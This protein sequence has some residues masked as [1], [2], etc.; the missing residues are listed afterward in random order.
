M[1]VWTRD[2]GYGSRGSE[3]GNRRP[4]CTGSPV[5]R[6]VAGR[7]LVAQWRRGYE[8]LGAVQTPGLVAG[9][10][11]VSWL[12][13][14]CG[15]PPIGT[16]TPIPADVVRP[17]QPT[18][19][20]PENA[21][22]FTLATPSRTPIFVPTSTPLP[23][24]AQVA[25]VEA[26]PDLRGSLVLRQPPS[27]LGIASG[28]AAIYDAPGG[29][30]VGRVPVGGLL[31]VTGRSADGRWL[32][33]YNE[34]AVFGWTPAG[35]LRL[36]G[37]EDLVVVEEAVDPAP[38]ATLLARVMEPVAVIDDILAAREAAAT[39]TA[40]APPPG[41]PT[42]AAISGGTI[43]PP[44]A[45]APGPAAG[46]NSL[47][48]TVT[49]SADVAGAPI[50]ALQAT[51]SAEQR[52]NLRTRPTTTAAI[53]AK[54]APGAAVQVTGRTVA[55][56]WLRVEAALGNGWIAAELVQVAGDRARLPIVSAE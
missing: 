35:Q 36:F 54:L 1:E 10:V 52:V 21:R 3:V 8:R 24:A 41:T 20:Y 51:I 17:V 56:D 26:P 14:A 48:P 4:G 40:Q 50:G 47:L 28:G 5:R 25:Q 12:L 53:V 46:A 30:A 7:S 43:P 13:A 45:A 6:L 33:V 15:G 11:L 42:G 49:P 55:G 29:R 44:A 16:P 31:T 32:S 27:A 34:E 2:S 22:V 19:D 39:A 9:I 37:D 38:V 18:P 23:S